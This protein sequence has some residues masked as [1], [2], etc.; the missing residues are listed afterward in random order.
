MP[1]TSLA[2]RDI[3]LRRRVERGSSGPWYRRSLVP[4]ARFR[5]D[6]DHDD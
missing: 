4:A 3:M 1:Y 2:G 5:H 6:D